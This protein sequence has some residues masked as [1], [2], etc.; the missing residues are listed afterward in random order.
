[1]RRF[2]SAVILLVALAFTALH[3]QQSAT[4]VL[5][6]IDAK[7]AHYADVA[8][9]IW[10]FAELGY[11]EQKSS[12]LLQSE[13]KA[14]GF[15]VKAGVA[16]IPTA[17][18]ATFGSGKP[19][20]AIVGEFDALPGLSQEASVASR[21]PIVAEAPGHG[22]GHNLLGTGALAAAVA[23]KDWLA[24]SGR[25]GTIRYYGTP[26]EEGGSGK[27]YMVRAGLFK[28]VDTVVTWHP[29]DRNDA[30]PASSLA[31][32]N[33]KFRFHGLASHA[34]AAPEKGRSALDAV[35]AMD[36]MVNMMREH[37]PQETRIHYIITRGGAAPNIVP[38]FAESYYYAR[39]PDMRILD[40]IWDR[41]VDAAK[42]AALGTG[43]TMDFEVLGAVYNVLPNVYL[44]GLM[45][46]NLERVGGFTYTPEEQA[47]AEEVRKTLAE[48]PTAPL[49][50]QQ[51]VQ[52]ARLGTVGSASTDLADVSWNV[53]TVSMTTATFVPGVP[54]HSW[55][56]TACAGG[57]I[58]V[59]GMIVAAKSMALTTI[60]LFSDPSH[61][62]KA[63]TEF[64]EKRG[65]NF[66]YKTRLADR[67]PALDYRK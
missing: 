15:D 20:I 57:T 58:G 27:V 56:A 10:G 40:R 47:F 25:P 33:A 66:V 24:S 37:V 8:H 41:I 63:R 19:V 6:N 60:D 48:D 13:L 42:G 23:A 55:Q 51:N 53:P 31:N 14:A 64:N 50:S 44:S 62:E 11:Q 16:D 38:D 49:G 4:S 28:D 3:A 29:G 35:E 18:V 22:C 36:Y 52:P 30:S 5:A 43:T 1:M 59:K 21:K 54:A 7:R 61:I 65:P 9:Q 17:F 46:K 34:A 32:I 39:Q 26:A 12:A 67:A 45:H 2:S